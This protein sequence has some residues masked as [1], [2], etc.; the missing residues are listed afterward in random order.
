MMTWKSD[1]SM[2]THEIGLFND[3]AQNLIIHDHT[4]NRIIQ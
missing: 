4:Q 1:Y 2:I 3:H